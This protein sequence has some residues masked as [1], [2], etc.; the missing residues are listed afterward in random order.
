MT[1]DALFVLSAGFG[2]R[3]G[4]IG[5]ILPKPLWPVFEK[6][7]LELQF[8]FYSW[9]NAEQKFIN[10]HHQALLLQRFV[11]KNI[12][13]VQCLYESELLGVGGGIINLKEHRPDLRSV[14]ISN[15]DQFLYIDKEKIKEAIKEIS[16]FDAILFAI[17]VQKVQGYHKLDVSREGRLLGINTCPREDHYWTYSGVALINTATITEKSKKAGLF[18]SIAHPQNRNVKV[19]DGSNC[20]YYDFG[21]LDL[22]LKQIVELYS[23]VKG[24]GEKKLLRFLQESNAIDLS[25][26]NMSIDSYYSAKTKEYRFNNLSIRFG[27]KVRIELSGLVDICDY[28]VC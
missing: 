25:K 19:I 16:L 14:L 28:S 22:Y 12:P 6:T 11:S 4:K 1:V 21:T 15:V 20:S 8:D 23:Q 9:V 26:A 3:M 27:E 18:Q 2:S 17:P 7:L 24:T 5:E 13:D 10:A